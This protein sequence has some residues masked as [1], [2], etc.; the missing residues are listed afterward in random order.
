MHAADPSLNAMLVHFA[1]L[2]GRGEEMDLIELRYR[3]FRGRMGQRFFPATRL[4]EA[5]RAAFELSR[6]RDVYFGVCPRTRRVG[7]RDAV[8]TAWALWADCD[9][10]QAVEELRHFN[11]APGLVVRSGTEGNC[12]AYWPL[13]DPL[14]PDEVESANRRLASVLGAD[15]E[16][17][18]AARVLRPASTLNFKS[19]PPTLVILDHVSGLAFDTGGLLEA[20][21]DEDPAEPIAPTELPERANDDLLRR[22]DPVIYVAVLTGQEVRSDRKVSCPFHRDRT[23]SLHVYETPEEGWFCFGCRRGGSVYDL[24]S[25]LFRLS[26]NGREFHELRRRLYAALLPGRPPG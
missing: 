14:M 18:D 16:S 19:T 17:T 10:P 23:P 12:H 24:G 25:A 22:I 4:G 3:R 2:F 26:T 8:T 20:L 1:A 11:P 7:R 21:P 5:A 15:V 13:T 9:G 6:R